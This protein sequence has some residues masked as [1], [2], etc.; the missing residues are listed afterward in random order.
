MTY[1]VHATIRDYDPTTNTVTVE[2]TGAGAIEQWISGIKFQTGVNKA[3]L[4][5]GTP[6]TLAMPDA[7]RICEAV[8]V[9]VTPIMAEAIVAGATPTAGNAYIEHVGRSIFYANSSGAITGATTSFPSSYSTL[10]EVHIVGD[11]GRS[12]SVTGLNLS[13]FIA[14]LSGTTTPQAGLKFTWR[15]FGQ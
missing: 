11:L 10:P 2:L 4:S 13:N 12:W 6:C 15:S 7:H 1:Q 9:D 5:S 3:H 14:A 8:V